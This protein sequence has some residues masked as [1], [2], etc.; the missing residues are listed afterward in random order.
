MAMEGR[1]CTCLMIL[2]ALAGMTAGEEE[3]WISNL[4]TTLAEFFF[5]DAS[6]GLGLHIL[7]SYNSLYIS[8]LDRQCLLSANQ[9]HKGH[10]RVVS[11]G[12][13]MFIQMKTGSVESRDFLVPDAYTGILSNADWAALQYLVRIL[14]LGSSEQESQARLWQSLLSILS[15]PEAG[16]LHKAA[17]ALGEAGVTGY[18]YPSVLPFFMTALRLSQM[19]KINI[20]AVRRVEQHQLTEDCLSQ[21]PPCPYQE[22]LGLCGYSCNCWKWVCGDCCYHLGC[23]EHDICCREKFVQIAC[24]FPLNFKCESGYAC[25]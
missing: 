6:T 18:D 1:L 13:S 2:A 9:A 15:Y 21:C 20:T 8:T 22:C 17:A 4:T 23:Y 14:N 5:T 19:Q 25:N 12:R 10:V 7:S 11:L 16:L 24:L 3:L